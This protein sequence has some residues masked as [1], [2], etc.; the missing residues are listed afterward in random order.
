MDDNVRIYSLANKELY[1]QVDM[2]R[3]DD[4]IGLTI[5]SE[6]DKN[7]VSN[8]EIRGFEQDDSDMVM[9]LSVRSPRG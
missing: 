4:Y 2:N 6:V 5:R 9:I 7:I 3:S 8:E 1:E